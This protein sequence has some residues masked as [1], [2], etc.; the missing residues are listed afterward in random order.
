MPIPDR[1]APVDALRGLA[2]LMVY[3]YHAWQI[4][5]APPMRI[6]GSQ[7]FLVGHFVNT[8]RAGVDLFMVLSG[9]CLFWPTAKRPASVA[10]WSW[11]HFARRRLQRIVPPYYASLLFVTILP[12]AVVVFYRATGHEAKWQPLP[13]GLQYLTHLLFVHTLFPQTW[14]GIQGVYWSLGL[15][16]QFYL[17]FPLVIWGYRHLGIRVVWY[18]AGLSL[19]YRLIAGVWTARAPWDIEF[20]WSITFLGRWMEFAAG[21][22]AAWVVARSG[23]GPTSTAN[24]TIAL[25]SAA[26][27]AYVL[28]TCPGD[29]L[30]VGHVTRDLLLSAC[31]ALVLVAACTARGRWRAVFGWKPLTMLGL[32]SY[33]LFLIHQNLAF[34]AGEGLRKVLRIEQPVIVFLLLITVV[35]AGITVLSGLFFRLFEFPFLRQRAVQADKR[36]AMHA[37]GLNPGF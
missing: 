21:M 31:F 17:V 16:M 29:S 9:F 36:P 19:A 27:A 25:L 1:L 20:L 33:S 8:L 28:A 7:V 14:M 26:V 13:G 18:M 35:L 32:V 22:L 3:V 37:D 2:G 23:D 6:L 5:G 10:A 24:R 4:A 11:R 30:R 15:E 34:Y 12:V